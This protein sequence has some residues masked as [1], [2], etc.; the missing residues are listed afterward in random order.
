MS[1]TGLVSDIINDAQDLIRQQLLLFRQDLRNDIRKMREGAVFLAAGIGVTVIAGLLLLLMVP[2]LLN[3]LVPT[4]PLWGCFGIVGGV[5]A[6]VG[7]GLLYAGARQFQSV[8]PLSDPSAEALKE[9]LRWT[10][11]PK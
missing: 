11:P 2:L 3:W 1:L 6:L 8:D 4:I 7:G 5:A 10:T 9:N